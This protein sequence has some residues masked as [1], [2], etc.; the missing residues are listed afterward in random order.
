MSKL[1]KLLTASI[2]LI[3]IGILGISVALAADSMY[4]IFSFNPGEGKLNF[5]DIKN[6]ANNYLKSYSPQNLKVVEIME[7]SQNYYIVVKEEDTGIGA[8]EL[9]A[10][11]TT[12]AI[13][14][15][16][17]PNIMWNLKYG[18]SMM[19]NF[20]ITTAQ[21]SMSIDQNS[22]IEI[23]NT[24]LKDSGLVEVSKNNAEKFYGYYTIDTLDNNG[25]ITGM[26]S[27]NGFTG[28]VWYHN[29]HGSFIDEKE[30]E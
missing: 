3:V 11:K 17:G 14:P 27:V 19:G 29:W 4:G 30:Y 13:Y 18:M 15:E 28:Q 22:A 2:I 1:K 10:D 12:G 25:K 9:L 6:N 7:F 23:A 26:L 20:Q 24:Y 21:A 16:Y 5:D 8:M